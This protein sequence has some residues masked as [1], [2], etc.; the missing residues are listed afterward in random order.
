MTTGRINQ[1]ANHVTPRQPAKPGYCQVSTSLRVGWTIPTGAVQV[2]PVATYVLCR[3]TQRRLFHARHFRLPVRPCSNQN[4]PKSK[5]TRLDA[6][7]P[8]H[9]DRQ[10]PEV[11]FSIPVANLLSQGTVSP[12]NRITIYSYALRKSKP[13]SFGKITGYPRVGRH[14]H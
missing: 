13:T 12:N 2:L 5:H 14:Y 6:K 9:W 11:Q 4:H 3:N 10:W 8:T 1:V 7:L